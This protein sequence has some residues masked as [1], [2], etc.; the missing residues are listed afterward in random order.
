MIIETVSTEGFTVVSEA[1][2][3]ILRLGQTEVK[4]ALE[5]SSSPQSDTVGQVE[6]S[7]NEMLGC[8]VE[9]P[10]S[11][12]IALKDVIEIHKCPHD[13]ER[14]IPSK[15]PEAKNDSNSQPS[16]SFTGKVIKEAEDYPVI[17]SHSSNS[18]DSEELQEYFVS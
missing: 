15:T 11:L 18:V 14:P 5:F 17:P 7:G 13:M 6:E 2:K 16:P 12:S 8:L 1:R 9:A 10:V 4:T 3:Y